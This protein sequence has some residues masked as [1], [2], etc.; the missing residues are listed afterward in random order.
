MP[1]IPAVDVTPVVNFVHKAVS[2]GKHV[3][4]SLSY[5]NTA[6]AAYN[7]NE[8]FLT[9]EEIYKYWDQKN[10]LRN[11]IGVVQE[12]SRSTLG[13]ISQLP[14][15]YGLKKDV[16]VFSED[17]ATSSEQSRAL[18]MIRRAKADMD[19]ELVESS[20]AKDIAQQ[21][22]SQLPSGSGLRNIQSPTCES[23]DFKSDMLHNI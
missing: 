21:P 2:T 6:E 9:P 13:S 4:E 1:T 3:E 20:I 17:F 14:P 18:E 12:K 22:R 11:R 10:V 15:A 7:R 16:R 5:I 23:S 19:R 8:A